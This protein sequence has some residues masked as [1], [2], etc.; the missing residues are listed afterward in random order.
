MK[1]LLGLVLVSFC[2]ADLNLLVFGDWGRDNEGEFAAAKGMETVAESL[3]LDAAVLLGDNFYSAG[4]KGDD[5]SPR[6]QKTF[7]NVYNGTAL[8]KLDFY[9]IAGNH[10]H[11]GNVSAQLCYSDDSK[12]WKYPSW[13]YSKTFN[14]SGSNKV[15]E[16][17]LFDSVIGLGNSDDNEDPFA[18][19]PGPSDPHTA[20]AQW[21]WL[22]ESMAKSTADYLFVGAHYPVWSICQHGPTKQLVDK[23]KPMLEHYGAHFMSGHDHC[24]GHIDEGKGPQYI[25]TGAGMSCCYSDTNKDKVPNGSVKFFTAGPGGSEYQPLPIQ[26]KSGFTTFRITADSMKVVYH[27]HEGT[28]LYTTPDFKPRASI[29]PPMPPSPPADSQENDLVV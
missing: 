2:K 29:P 4:I 13:W 9:A 23:V 8:E 11:G 15:F 20:A 12:R 18:Q 5:H 17:L 16:M 22:E 6:F 27:A 3:K 14:I 24:L 19:P 28:E 26:M 10:D 21:A 1:V 7:E 25:I